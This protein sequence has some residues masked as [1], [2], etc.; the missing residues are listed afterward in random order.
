M[1]HSTHP[2]I[3]DAKDAPIQFIED[4][5][6]PVMA[7]PKCGY[8]YTHIDTAAVI[9]TSGQRAIVTANGE[10]EGSSVKVQ[11]T[12]RGQARSSRRHD[13]RLIVNCEAGCL[14]SIIF[15]QHKG[16]TFVEIV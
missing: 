3:L 16:T 7:C 13:V 5:H 1:N 4:T 14:S 2:G 8:E 15:I 11:M 6:L 9:A 10:D 12:G